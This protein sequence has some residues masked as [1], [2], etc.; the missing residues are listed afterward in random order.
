MPRDAPESFQRIAYAES[1]SD[2]IIDLIEIDDGVAVEPFRYARNGVDVVHDGDT[3]RAVEFEILPPELRGDGSF[4][5]SKLKIDA[6]DQ[7][8]VNLIRNATAPM[9][10]VHMCVLLSDPDA[11]T[12]GPWS[13]QIR[14]DMV[15]S[16]EVMEMSLTFEPTLQE[17]IPWKRLSPSRAP[18]LF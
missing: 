8:V 13:Y 3:Y 9:S 14:G 16:A 5:Q 18:G 1:S 12:H 7:E 10:L 11:I 15:W 6:V 4:V 17:A 2:G